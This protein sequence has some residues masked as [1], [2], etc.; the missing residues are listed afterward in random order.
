MKIIRYITRKSYGDSS[1]KNESSDITFSPQVV[2][3]HKKEID[4]GLEKHEGE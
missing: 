2:P 1:P 3:N 4:T